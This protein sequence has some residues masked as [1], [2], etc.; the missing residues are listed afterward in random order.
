L[1]AWARAARALARFPGTSP[2]MGF[3]CARV[4][5]RRSTVE[6]IDLSLF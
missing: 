2:M 4:T 5:E 1:A 3:S 6:A